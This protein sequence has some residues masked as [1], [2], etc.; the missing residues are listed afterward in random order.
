MMPPS[1]WAYWYRTVD[2]RLSWSTALQRARLTVSAEVFNLFN[3]TNYSGFF[4]TRF[5]QQG[6]PLASFGQ[7]N[8]TFAPRQGQ[9][10]LRVEF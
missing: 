1:E 4:G 6:N 8:G 10:G 3:W 7:P 2:V 5:D 9:F